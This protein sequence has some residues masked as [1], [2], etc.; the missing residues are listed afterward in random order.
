M[1]NY[2]DILYGT[3][4]RKQID[5]WHSNPSSA[6]PLPDF[7]VLRRGF[8]LILVFPHI[9]SMKVKDMFDLRIA[10]QCFV[11]SPLLIQQLQNVTKQ[12]PCC[13]RPWSDALPPTKLLEFSFPIGVDASTQGSKSPN[14]IGSEEVDLKVVVLVRD[15]AKM[16][17]GKMASQ[18]AHAVLNVYMLASK[19]DPKCCEDWRNSGERIGLHLLFH[20]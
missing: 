4:L 7:R 9:Y 19:S 2:K 13:P 3:D 20:S 14:S 6:E 5:L 15:D 1:P 17:S 18:V 16:Q 8:T 12:C 10:K 11:P